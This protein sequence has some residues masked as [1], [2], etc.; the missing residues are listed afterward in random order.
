MLTLDIK[1]KGKDCVLKI[2]MD[3]QANVDNVNNHSKWRQEEQIQVNQIL[4]KGLTFFAILETFQIRCISTNNLSFKGFAKF[5][6]YFLPKS[7]ASH[8]VFQLFSWNRK[9][10]QQ[11]CS[12]TSLQ[13]F[14]QPYTDI[15]NTELC[16]QGFIIYTAIY[17]D[18]SS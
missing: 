2:L 11:A 1:D 15:T 13:C 7:P 4:C 18:I 12:D 8:N 14:T 3:T 5:A 10:K 17:W 6:F 16:F 9:I